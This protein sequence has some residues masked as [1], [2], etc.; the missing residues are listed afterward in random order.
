MDYA[1][2]AY[3]LQITVKLLS[4]FRS[5]SAKGDGRKLVVDDDGQIDDVEVQA[6]DAYLRGAW[7]SRN[8]PVGVTH[9]LR[10]EARGQCGCCAG[11]CSVLEEAHINRR[12]VEVEHY[13]QHPH[14]LILLCPTCHAR[15]DSTTDK[16]INN[17][18]IKHSKEV[19]LGRLMENVKTDIERARRVQTAAEELKAEWRARAGLSIDQRWEAGAVEFFDQT[20]VASG[21]RQLP[22]AG[23]VR[24]QSAADLKDGL[25]FLSGALAP[26]QPVTSSALDGYAEQVGVSL[27]PIEGDPWGW[28]PKEGEC[29]RC[30][31]AAM[32]E[33]A[34]CANCETSQY[35]DDEDQYHI[36]AHEDG[37]V[38]ILT[39]DARGEKQAVRCDDCDSDHFTEI[40]YE[41]YC[42]YCQ[43]M[44]GKDD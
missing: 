29:S 36:D 23:A 42:S 30:G 1:E 5:Y 34:V 25:A 16:F 22:V 44:V 38:R 26:T 19:L 28:S 3:H 40:E 18:I 6:F 20:V 37:G 27:D 9:E 31:E 10:R 41:T 43:H 21:L 24:V 33:H 8:V 39:E 7:P 4:W 15:Y 17:E 14:N 2:A 13:F 32:I 35:L 11:P 12:G